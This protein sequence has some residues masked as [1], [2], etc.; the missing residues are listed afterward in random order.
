MVTAERN[1]NAV[2]SFEEFVN[3][4]KD[5]LQFRYPDCKVKVVHAD[6]NNGLRLTGITILPEGQTVVPT[7]YMEDFYK[8]YQADRWIDDIVADA[9][10]LYENNKLQEDF[11]LPDVTDFEV[12]KDIICFK[13]INRT[14][15]REKLS[16]MPHRDF[17]DLAIVYFIPV[18]IDGGKGGTIT[19][20]DYLFSQWQTDEET[21][22]Q[23]AR[24]NTKRLYPV[25]RQSMEDVIRDMMGA[26]VPEGL[27]S[28]KNGVPNIP[29][30]VLRCNKGDM[31]NAAAMLYDDILREFGQEYGNFYILPSSIFEVLLVPAGP[32]PADSSFVC[33]MVRSVNA[34]QV[35]P[36]EILSD[37]AYYYH[38]DTGEIEILS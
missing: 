25:I 3:V 5:R 16:S 26:D 9:V 31:S 15:N 28:E 21:V 11:V 38:A 8:D 23:Y 27:F 19:V 4:M 36:N 1:S 20:T 14:R 6:K 24:E 30:F 32:G 12:V 2:M 29:M 13:L 17:L 33:P 37:N 34:E 7:I 35:A 10:R 22:Y 18:P